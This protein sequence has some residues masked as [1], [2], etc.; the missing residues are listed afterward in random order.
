[1]PLSFEI[2]FIQFEQFRSEWMNSEHDCEQ[3]TG[4]VKSTLNELRSKLDVFGVNEICRVGRIVEQCCSLLNVNYVTP[5]AGVMADVVQMASDILLH[6]GK[7]VSYRTTGF[8]FQLCRYCVVDVRRRWEP[9]QSSSVIQ[10]STRVVKE[11]LLSFY[12]ITKTCCEFSIGISM[13][14]ACKSH[15]GRHSSELSERFIRLQL[16]D[17][18]YLLLACSPAVANVLH[19]L[20]SSESSQ[21]Q[22]TSSLIL[23]QWLQRTASR[24]WSS[25]SSTSQQV[26]TSMVHCAAAVLW[27]CDCVFDLINL[28]FARLTFNKY[29]M[30]SW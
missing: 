26:S 5:R 15:V 22:Q 27:D 14:T 10:S 13:I 19:E 3:W 18:S 29:I 9:Q 1:M 17:T 30:N 6:L 24:C 7:V 21:Q 25:S 2:W 20:C 12:G 4:E 8:I 11:T 23:L 16:Q 28:D